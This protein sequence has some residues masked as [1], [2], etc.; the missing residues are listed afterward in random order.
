MTRRRSPWTRQA[1]ATTAAP[2]VSADKPGGLGTRRGRHSARQADPRY[3]WSGAGMIRIPCPKDGRVPVEPPRSQPSRPCSDARLLLATEPACSCC[4]CG[5][6]LPSDRSGMPYC[7]QVPRVPTRHQL[8]TAPSTTGAAPDRRP[9][10]PPVPAVTH[11]AGV[12]PLKVGGV[13]SRCPLDA[14][15][16]CAWTTTTSQQLGWAR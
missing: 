6:S 5:P 3:G 12:A 11:P 8:R 4:S 16:P 13:G 2:N 9:A 1:D 10:L 7:W 14:A 15:R